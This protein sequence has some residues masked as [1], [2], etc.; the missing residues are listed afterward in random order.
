M[1]NVIRHISGSQE[2]H[3][4]SRRDLSRTFPQNIEGRTYLKD[5]WDTSTNPHR[6][7]AAMTHDPRMQIL[8]ARKKPPNEERIVQN[9]LIERL[10]YQMENENGV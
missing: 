6:A 7:L 4:I 1:A 8:R 2:D 9:S 3:S 5:N 10:I